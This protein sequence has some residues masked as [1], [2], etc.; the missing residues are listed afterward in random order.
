MKH[1]VRSSAI[2]T[3]IHIPLIPKIAGSIRIAAI[4][5]IN[6]LRNEMVA[7]ISPLLSAVKKAEP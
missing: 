6:V 4:W 3:A 5:K 1:S 7:E 2:A